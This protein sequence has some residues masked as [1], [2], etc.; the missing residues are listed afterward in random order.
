MKFKI[1]P[2]LYSPEHNFNNLHF[3]IRKT[4]EKT[5]KIA[6]VALATKV[7]ED[8]HV[9]LGLQ[10]SYFHNV[11]MYSIKKIFFFSK[12]A[13]GPANYYLKLMNLVNHFKIGGIFNW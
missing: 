7:A 2:K 9:A 10:V 5:R 4:L 13:K 6:A 1:F 8:I 12:W 11:V 3:P